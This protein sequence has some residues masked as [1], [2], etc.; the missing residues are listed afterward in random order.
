MILPKHIHNHPKLS[1]GSVQVDFPWMFSTPRTLFISI[2]NC[3][4]ATV[5]KI[6]PKFI[7]LVYYVGNEMIHPFIYIA[8]T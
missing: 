1:N 5:S 4:M 8:H 3:G 6:F 2:E 7:Y